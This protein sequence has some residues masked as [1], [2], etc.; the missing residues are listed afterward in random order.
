M[1]TPADPAVAALKGV[2]AGPGDAD[3]DMEADD[4]E[5][6]NTR[7]VKDIQGE[8]G[9]RQNFNKSRDATYSDDEDDMPGGQRVQC[10]QQ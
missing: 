5:E 3:I 8:L 10:S 4:V 2:L 9:K 7:E 6:V 1:H